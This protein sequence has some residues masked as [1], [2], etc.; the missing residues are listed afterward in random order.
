MSRTKTNLSAILVLLALLT[1]F[2]CVVASAPASAQGVSYC[3]PVTMNGGFNENGCGAAMG[4]T[5]ARAY[6]GPAGKL[7]ICL[8]VQANGTYSSRDCSTTGGGKE[9]EILTSTL[10]VPPARGNMGAATVSSTIGG[11]SVEVKCSKGLFESQ[12]K[13]TG[14]SSGGLMELKTCEVAKPANC[15]VAEP[16]KTEFNGQLEEAEKKVLNKL[17]GSKAG[18]ELGEISFVGGS[19]AI[20]GTTKL[21]GTQKCGFDSEI[22]LLKLEHEVICKKTGSKLTLGAE[23]ASYAGTAS[24][25]L[26]KVEEAEVT[27]EDFG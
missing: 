24:K 14:L 2:D 19:C 6:P 4:T 23:P 5:W 26:T 27:W 3:V 15:T 16:I 8:K 21:K 10:P 7:T 11:T 12:P 20:A 18:E 22:E 25:V 13:E 17:T 1:P 9:W